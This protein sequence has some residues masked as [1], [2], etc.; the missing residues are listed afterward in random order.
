MKEDKNRKPL[1]G[2]DERDDELPDDDWFERLSR[3]YPVN[4]EDET[5][6]LY[7]EQPFA[8]GEDPEEDFSEEFP[9]QENEETAPTEGA[10]E[11]TPPTETADWP[12]PAEDA[13]A[14]EVWDEPQEDMDEAPR[15]KRLWLIPVGILV[16]LLGLAVGCIAG[17]AALMFRADTIYNGVAVE[18]I[19]L[20]GM[21][22]AQAEEILTEAGHRQ[23]DDLS[24]TAELPLDNA[25]T[26]TAADAGLSYTVKPAARAAWNYGRDGGFADNLVKF[27]SSRFLG[28]SSFV[29]DKGFDPQV[30]GNA[31]L[32][33]VSGPMEQLNVLLMEKS[34]DID[35]EKGEI[36]LIKGAASLTVDAARLAQDYVDAFAAGKSSFTYEIPMSTDEDFDFRGL[37]DEIH[38]EMRDACIV[39]KEE[40]PAEE[41]TEE[42]PA[43]TP[44]G[45]TPTP[46][47]T[48]TPAPETAAEP[49]AATAE[50][51]TPAPTVD[52]STVDFG[53][54]PYAVVPSSEGID[55]DV[56]AAVKAWDAAAPG[57]TV[58]IP[59]QVKLPAVTTEEL[60]GKLFADKLSKNWTMVKIYGRDYCDE[61]RTALSGSTND[62]ISNVKKACELINDTIL[63]PGQ[64]FS[65]NEALGERTEK[66]G[67][68]PATAYA[69]G[70]VRQEYGGGI[71]QVSS[72][73]YNA[74]LLAN[75]KI[76]E[77]ECHQFQV[78]YLP[79]GM[80][81]T[82]SWGWPDFRFRNDKNYP[83]KI[84]AWVD[85]DTNECC[86]QIVGTDEDH[87]YVIMRFN[88]WEIFDDT[89]TYHDADGNPLAVGMAAST[90]RMIYH[91][92]DDY[93]T[94]TPISE[95]Y[96]VYS[97]Y[98]YHTEDIEARNVPLAAG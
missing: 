16:G 58:V 88:N 48:A 68:K 66:N 38:S 41:E 90:W 96:E 39:Y 23:F 15:K 93:N 80:D 11:E 2:R 97:T 6:Y 42:Q 61:V 72:T 55:F 87:T 50:E 20:S 19:D 64:T 91:D 13:P 71:C 46:A 43:A 67:W 30:D 47:P 35:K 7:E 78:G 36:R 49:T 45:A 63:C 83:V 24:V 33:K 14:A 84:V 27:A 26:V 95:E 60:E 34:V 17:A 28:K 75:L 89:D 37:Y 79:W 4:R 81:A 22:Y 40:Y 94:A 52:K 57:D 77:R 29:W 1:S 73:L 69:N 76:V 44:P 56:A 85:D 31:I 70:E 92:G 5:E 51:P 3:E 65:Y 53:E 12:E 8:E 98:K 32:T 59:M 10:Y 86:V 18:G 74:V 21:T 54:L 25:Y 82:V 62:R 9:V